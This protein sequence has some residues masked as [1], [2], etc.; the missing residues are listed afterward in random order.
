M[1]K[2]IIKQEKKAPNKSNNSNKK[3]NK[4]GE[5]IVIFK[6][7]MNV[8]DLSKELGVSNAVVIKSLMNLG[9]MASV[10]V[11]LDRDTVELVSMELGYQVKN[12]VITDV[13]RYDEFV[14]VDDEENLEQRPP[15]VTVMGHVDHGKTTLLDTIRKSR[16]TAGEAGGITQHIGAYQ[17]NRKGKKIT[18]IDTPGHAAFTEMR[19]RGAKVTDIVVL[20]VAADDG[21][22]PQT[23]EAL[24]HAKAAKTSIIVAVNKVDKPSA[25]PDHVMTELSNH[26]LLPEEWGGDTPFIK[27]SAL[28]K[29][30][31]DEL[32]D[33]IELVSELGDYKAN[34]N[35]E[36]RGS[37]I[38]AKL[39]KGKGPVATFIVET[40]TLHIGDNVVVGN[41]YGKIRTMEDDLQKRYKEAGPSKAIEVTGLNSVPLAGDV[42]MV[43]KDEKTARQIAESRIANEREGEQKQM[44][45]TL[46]SMFGQMGAEVKELNL[47]I[48][49]DVQ[50]SIEA[51][52]NVLQ[53]INIEGLQVNIVRGSV[54][55]I[56]E[57]DVSLASA[58]NAIVIGF[59]VRPMGNVRDVADKE[60]VEIR[61]YNIIYR[62]AEDIEKAL[63]GMLEPTFEEVVI[64]QV[65][66]RDTFKAS[67]IGTIAGGYVTDGVVKRDALVRIIRDGIV[68]YEGKLASLK[69]FKDDVKEV[70][71]GYE[72][73]LSIVNYN[74]IKVGD[75]IEVSEMKEV[76]VA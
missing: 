29:E 18:F 51:L 56:T 2:K 38:E 40:G 64:G 15:I 20:V 23:L 63:K 25:N 42:F 71:T 10:N 24:D 41:T 43:F 36:A 65:E 50:G 70:K 66:V 28:K 1:A 14:I 67:K 12:E 72:C 61:L 48:K 5:K 54:G 19:K 22:M 13:V 30:G 35:R 32:L 60:G 59:N 39:D 4:A 8:S 7:G 55:A 26:G 44:K 16:V 68:V 75:I 49:A 45:A 31:I 11:S 58:S 6:E 9:I 33:M 46:D 52:K 69:R 21:V 17:V 27:I 47:L 37:V 73:G 3:D 34:P 62:V 53:T 57:S 76:E 74:D